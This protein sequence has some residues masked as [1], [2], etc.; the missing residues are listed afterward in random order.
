MLLD[1]TSSNAIQVSHARVEGDGPLSAR[2]EPADV[3]VEVC[4]PFP[5]PMQT[6]WVVCHPHLGVTAKVWGGGRTEQPQLLDGPRFPGQFLGGC[7]PQSQHLSRH[8]Q[9]D[10]LDQPV[11]T[12]QDRFEWWRGFIPRWL[13]KNRVRDVTRRTIHPC[14]DKCLVQPSACRPNERLALEHLSVGRRLSHDDPLRLAWAIPQHDAA[15]SKGAV[16]AATE[17]SMGIHVGLLG[18][19]A[20]SIDRPV[21]ARDRDA[22]AP[23]RCRSSRRP[24][25]PPGPAE[26]AARGDR[27]HPERLASKSDA[28]A[29]ARPSSYPHLHADSSC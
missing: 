6:R 18:I 20:R 17:W 21:P 1:L 5:T 25:P 27:S 7:S 8:R 23:M 14:V 22:A 28:R 10:L 2:A 11:M 9:L 15:M 4:R 19:R 13:A 3:L 16:T 26:G 24:S 12:R 29:K